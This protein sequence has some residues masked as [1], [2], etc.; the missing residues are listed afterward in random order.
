MELC[1]KA[2]N[3]LRLRNAESSLQDFRLIL[4]IGDVHTFHDGVCNAH[5]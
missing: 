4:D 5:G 1:G 2:M 3:T